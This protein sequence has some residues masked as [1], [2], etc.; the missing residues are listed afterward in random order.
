VNLTWFHAAWLALG[1]M[2]CLPYATLHGRALRAAP[3]FTAGAMAIV[4]AFLLTSHAPPAEGVREGFRWVGRENDFMA[5]VWES[6]GLVGDGSALSALTV[7]GPAVLALPFAWAALAWQAFRRN[8]FGLLPWAVTVPLLALQAARQVRF[9]DALALP[10]AVALAWG[11]V[12]AARKLRRRLPRAVVRSGWAPAAAA[13]V[14]V[15]LGQAGTVASTAGAIAAGSPG[16]PPEPGAVTMREMCDWVRATTGPGDGSVMARWNWGHTIEWAAERPSVATNFGTYVGEESFRD[17]SAFFLAEDPARAEELMEA[18]RSRFV[19][20]TTRLPATYGQMIR[21]VDPRLADRYLKPAPG[22][23]VD[24]RF[25]WFRTM[26]ARLMYDGAVVT[27][28]RGPVGSLSFLRLIHVSP[29][30]DPRPNPRGEPS[31]AGWIWERVPGAIVE[32]PGEP[33]VEAELMFRVRYAAGGYTGEW[34]YS[35]LCGEDGVARIRVPISTDAPN[36]DG[37][38]EQAAWRCAGS[39]GSLAVPAAAVR[40]GGSVTI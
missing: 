13:A 25:E 5:S 40:G 11:A 14:A 15:G 20:V 22:G 28:D 3:A 10:M 18:R 34:I 8:R 17:P 6:R 24:L 33:G 31:P 12:E 1:A 4:A 38:V 26:G 19:A 16:Q 35:G 36:G 32:V 7:L 9:A 30:R 23:R 37:V 29:R 27:Q 39:G 21:D 2:V